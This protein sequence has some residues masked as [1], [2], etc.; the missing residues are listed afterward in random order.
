M[1]DSKEVI[2]K[3]KIERNGLINQVNKLEKFII[4][5]YKTMEYSSKYL[6]IKQLEIMN[7]YIDI[8]SERIKLLLNNLPCEKEPIN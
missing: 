3:L 7:N 6:L 8:L 4:D 1:Q 2:N 5:N